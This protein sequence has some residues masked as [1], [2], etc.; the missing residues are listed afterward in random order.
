MK[1]CLLVSGPI[2]SFKQNIHVLLDV[3][4][5]I[6]IEP[7][8]YLH[9]SF[10]DD[11]Q[12]MSNTKLD[13]FPERHLIKKLV[14]EDSIDIPPEFNTTYKMK[15]IYRQWYRIYQLHSLLHHHTPY[16]HLFFRLRSDLC[17]LAQQSQ[18]LYAIHHYSP[19]S[20]AIPS[21]FD[22]HDN[23]L[24]LELN[25]PPSINDQ[26]AF[27]DF[28]AISKYASLLLHLNEFSHLPQFSEIILAH[29]LQSK[30][31][32]IQRFNLP[33]KLVLSPCHVIAILGDSGSGKSTIASVLQPLLHHNSLLLEQDRYHKW[34]RNHPNWKDFTHLNPNANNLEKFS[35][36]LF[37]LKIG[38]HIFSVDYDHHSGTFTQ[39]Q[40]LSPSSHIILCGLHSFST[41]FNPKHLINLKVFIDTHEHLKFLWKAQ[42]DVA[43]RGYSTLKVFQ[44][45]SSRL[46]DFQQFIL[47]QK[48]LA[49]VIIHIY[50]ND[51]LPPPSPDIDLSLQPEAGYVFLIKLNLLHLFTPFSFLSIQKKDQDM[52]SINV[53]NDSF[54]IV[55]T[56]LQQLNIQPEPSFFHIQFVFSVLIYQH[57]PNSS[58]IIPSY[59]NTTTPLLYNFP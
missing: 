29:F 23:R 1:V 44:I 2:R 18:L 8:I 37:N 34:E 30:D 24:L 4:K 10:D 25:N 6:D 48:S 36:D 12:Y 43:S 57:F 46:S 51:P 21:G 5:K 55:S 49:D 27:G 19:H 45:Y 22:F 40:L 59:T 41:T 13:D 53:P 35:H 17:L 20:I 32:H 42:R 16:Y 11:D 52:F 38:N 50:S 3:F 47:P 31:I 15:N 7:D 56:L 14:I 9:T 58:N 39:P 54:P 28:Y 33:Y 26:F